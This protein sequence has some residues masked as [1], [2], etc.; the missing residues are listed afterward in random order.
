MLPFLSRAPDREHARPGA[1]ELQGA[2][3]ADS[4]A[5]ARDQRDLSLERSHDLAL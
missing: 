5:R 1:G 3:A 2:A 4:P